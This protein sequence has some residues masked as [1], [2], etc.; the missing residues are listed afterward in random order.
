[1]EA[2][3]AKQAELLSSLSVAMHAGNRSACA[4]VLNEMSALNRSMANANQEPEAKPA[5]KKRKPK[6]KT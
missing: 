1:M 6:P 2:Y 3:F 4:V 5:R